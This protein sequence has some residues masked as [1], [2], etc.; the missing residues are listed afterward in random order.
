MKRSKSTQIKP[1]EMHVGQH[2]STASVCGVVPSDVA[3][4]LSVWESTP[5]Q[6]QTS[7]SIWSL[8]TAL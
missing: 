5:F 3:L 4:T 6:A 1:I 7:S 8:S 2:K